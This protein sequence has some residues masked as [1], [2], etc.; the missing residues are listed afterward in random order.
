MRPTRGLFAFLLAG[1]VLRAADTVVVV[2]PNNEAIRHEYGLGFAAWYRARTGRDAAVDWR[3]LGGTSEIARLLRGAY[4]GSFRAEWT[5]RLGRAWTAAVEA[6]FQDPALPPSAPPEARE[7]R[8]AF[9]ASEASC[10]IDVFFG[11]GIPDLD[12]QAAFG[13]IVDGGAQARHP[14]WFTAE[15]MPETYDGSRLRDAQGRWYGS[16]LSCYGILYNRDALR[17]LGFERPPA[18]WDDLADPRFAGRIGVCDPQ[19]S[20]SIAMAFE[21]LIQQK[22]HRRLDAG[23]PGA[24]AVRAGWLDGLRLI[25]RIAANAR[26]FTDSSQ[27]PPV[28]VADGSCA[29]GLCIDFYGAEEEEAV[30]RRGAP[31]R[32]GFAIPPGGT[33]YFV[34]PIALLRGAPHP[35]AARAF[36][37]FALSLEGQKLWAFRPGT[38]G[39]PVDYALRRLPVRRDFYAR[40]DWKA[41][42]S[43]PDADPYRPG[44]QMIFH[45]EWTDPLF[46]EM[47]FIIHVMGEDTHEELVRA[48]RAIQAAPE[49]ARSRALEEIQDLSAVSYDRAAGP[50]ARALGSRETVAQVR[51]ARELGD[52]FRRRYARAEALAKGEAAR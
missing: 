32:L 19:K 11:G 25:Q 28:D 29:A 22:I 26:Y 14:D 6:G 10:G 3:V 43:D 51:L 9:L 24:E 34:D 13:S 7:A 23:M 16:V 36:L 30:A 21:N 39:G 42:R 50:L 27:K 18:S 20:G 4:T 48:W 2:T 1:A 38:P 52:E 40:T 33:A 5:G 41:Y 49:P 35:D 31:G 47:A 8:A 15:T 45:P 44:T 37:D 17:L 46:P 12:R